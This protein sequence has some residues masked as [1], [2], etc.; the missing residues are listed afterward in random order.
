MCGVV[1]NVMVS[2]ISTTRT[3]SVPREVI[4]GTDAGEDA[5]EKVHAHTGRGHAGPGV[6]EQRNSA[7]WRM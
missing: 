7:T 4:A 1:E 2:L 6:G 5:V 3:C